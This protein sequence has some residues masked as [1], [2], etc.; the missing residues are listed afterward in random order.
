MEVLDWDGEEAL[1][2]RLVLEGL[3]DRADRGADPLEGMAE[4]YGAA[5]RSLPAFRVRLQNARKLPA[6]RG[7]GRVR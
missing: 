6:A 4:V 3:A 1:V 5:Q 7:A 2:N